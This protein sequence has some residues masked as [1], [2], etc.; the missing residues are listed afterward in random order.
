MLS[1]YRLRGRM[2][3]LRYF[4]IVDCVV[5]ASRACGQKLAKR[6]TDQSFLDGNHF[7]R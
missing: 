4:V 7:D 1:L 3:T 6:L 5:A 2:K